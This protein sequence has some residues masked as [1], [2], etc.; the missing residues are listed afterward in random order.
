V[1]GTSRSDG[2]LPSCA[3]TGT[4]PSLAVLLA[5]EDVRFLEYMIYPASQF[6]VRTVWAPTEGARRAT[7][8]SA[9]GSRRGASPDLP[10]RLARISHQ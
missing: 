9:Q 4:L 7:E 1:F 10:I 3:T 8:V 5:R 2:A 6:D